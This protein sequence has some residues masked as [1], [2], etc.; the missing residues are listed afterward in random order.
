MDVA[1]D[2]ERGIG[3]DIS[4]GEH[5]EA[6]LDNFIT[7]RHVAR[8]RDE[9]ERQEEELW[10]QSERRRA[11]AERDANREAWREY[12]QEQAVRHRKSLEALVAHHEQ[13]AERLRSGVA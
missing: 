8:I 12:H 10:K 3:R 13:K 5:V 9:G 11:A 2:P 4:S 7:R 6:D 1:T